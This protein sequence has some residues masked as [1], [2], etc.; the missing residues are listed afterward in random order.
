MKQ[1]ARHTMTGK[2]GRPIMTDEQVLEARALQDFA[3]WSLDEIMARFPD[4]KR[5][6][7]RQVLDYLNRSR[8]I[9]QPHHLPDGVEEK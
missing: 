3:D 7:M 4:I 5:E 2:G 8:L 9:P 1:S 6:T